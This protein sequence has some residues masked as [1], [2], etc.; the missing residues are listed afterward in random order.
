[1]I[2]EAML[3]SPLT[4]ERIELC[5]DPS[6]ARAVRNRMRVGDVRFSDR[7]DEVSALIRWTNLPLD[8]AFEGRLVHG[9]GEVTIGRFCAL[10]GEVT[11]YRFTAKVDQP[12][13]LP[14]NLHLLPCPEKAVDCAAQ[15]ISGKDIWFF[16]HP[17]EDD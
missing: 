10:A 17:D 15:R 12:F 11:G 5:T 4:P 13:V 3:S 1:L 16:V 9:G 7:G 2:E 8:T 6:L 14:V